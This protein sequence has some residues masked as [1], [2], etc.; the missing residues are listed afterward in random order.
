MQ[1]LVSSVPY[2]PVHPRHL[3]RDAALVASWLLIV[4]GFIAQVSTSPAVEPEG[5]AP[6]LLASA[7]QDLGAFAS[8][9]PAAYP[10]CQAARP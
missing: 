5:A 7:T 10:P 4:G 1:S 6:T 8:G 3:A 2:F 9:T